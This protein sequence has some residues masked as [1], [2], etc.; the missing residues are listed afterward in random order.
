MKIESHKLPLALIAALLIISASVAGIFG[1]GEF[2]KSV[3][4]NRLEKK[5][6]DQTRLTGKFVDFLTEGIETGSFFNLY[7]EEKEYVKA[8][9]N[10]I[11]LLVY[12]DNGLEY[13]SD[14]TFEV[15]PFYNQELFGEAVI[16]LQN[17]WFVPVISDLPDYK[18]VGLLRV[19][20]H[21]GIENDIISS[22][23]TEKLKPSGEIAFSQQRTEGGMAIFNG[24]GDYLF[25]VSFPDN[26]SSNILVTVSLVLWTLSLIT[27]LFIVASIASFFNK[28]GKG[29]LGILLASAVLIS[30]YF[31]FLFT[32]KPSV[33]NGTELFSPLIFSLNGLIPSLGH[34]LVV[35]AIIFTTTMLMN[36]HLPVKDAESDTTLPQEISVVL[37]FLAG[38]LVVCFAHWIFS[39]ILSE[40]NI[41]LEFYKIL[42]LNYLSIVA[43]ISVMITFFASFPLFLRAIRLIK[44]PTLKMSIFPFAASLAVVALLFHNNPLTIFAVTTLLLFQI[45]FAV[46]TSRKKLGIFNL[47]VLYSLLI[48][49]YTLTVIA[50]YSENKRDEK[51]K[52]QALDFSIEND[53]D[54]EMLLMDLWP[55]MNADNTLQDMMSV[56]RFGN[57]DYIMINDY[58]NEN[59]F[60]DYWDNYIVSIYL[61]EE[62]Q[63]IQ[64]DDGESTDCF[65]FFE[66]RINEH[67]HVIS[68]TDFY[69]TDDQ[70]GRTCYL[71][72]LYFDVGMRGRN[73]LFIELFSDVNIFQPGY[74]ELLLDKKYRTNS[75]LSDY[76][77]IKYISGSTVISYGEYDYNSE[78]H[79]YTAGMQ[80]DYKIFKED[81]FKHILFKNGETTVVISRPSLTGPNLLISFAYLFAF[82]LILVNISINLTKVHRFNPVRSPNLRQKFQI[83]IIAILLISSMFVGFLVANLTI[84]RY[85]SNHYEN[86]K[87]KIVS[88]SLALYNEFAGENIIG[89]PGSGDINMNLND[90][91]IY[92]SNIFNTD[93]NLYDTGGGLVATS[94]PELF[95]K[96][97]S[98]TR[99]DNTA[100][101]N[102]SEYGKTGF[103][104][105]EKVGNLK[106]I[107]S[108][109]PFTNGTGKVIG[110]LN[111][112]YFRMQS[113]FAKE[114]SDMIVAVVNFTL[115]LII[116]TMGIAVFIVGKIT[117]PLSMLSRGLAS[118]ELG[119]KAEHIDYNDQDEIGD[120]IKQYNLMVDELDESATKLANSER[121]YA[122]REMAK[123]IAHEIKNPLTPMKL[124]VQ[125]LHKS[126]KDKVGDFDSRMDN[127]AKNQIE[128][129]DNLSSIASAFSS[130]A[131][132]PGNKPSKIDL[133]DQIKTTL[134]LFR[135]SQNIAFQESWPKEKKVFVYAD[136]E[137]LNGV[138][139]NLIKNGIQSIPQGK[140]GVIV[141]S[142]KVLRDKCL[143]SIADNGIGIPE[144]VREKMFT[145]YFTTKS[146]G[147]GLGLSIV[148]K[149]V[150]SCGGKIWFESDFQKGTTFFVEL[151]LMFTVEKPGND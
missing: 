5:V 57:D 54:A 84:S 48:S 127:F 107:S 147:T 29:L 21:Y 141:V 25:T 144:D 35:S 108:Y 140:E 2:G 39:R 72:K 71:G 3:V 78:D 126:F 40:S 76:S 37:L 11:T 128:Y 95:N 1:K 137:Q 102:L 45:V 33:V 73:G 69:F 114:I 142:L 112:P 19:S 14:N 13:W 151:P 150:E 22:G 65:T 53:P 134:D 46:L 113:S 74:S 20:T 55:E 109:A 23:L 44:G 56:A 43:Y 120:L 110:F 68:G 30:T 90:V 36:I 138:F 77:F 124:N 86:I 66:E 88:V 135:S 16:F 8:T 117:A 143:V 106:Y 9:K 100:L 59:Y 50:I 148:K 96:D 103:S 101:I 82:A 49:I 87:E 133:V 18:I 60:R 105:T 62:R 26:A 99:M 24:M 129:I 38:S 118:V 123:Q 31:L 89:E 75:G 42:D 47:T 85:E 28:I 41:N 10:D 94:R 98:S 7:F 34:L 139:S 136:R 92:L 67:G 104:H 63:T 115:L 15:P 121:E 52:I 32:G 12:S 51:I 61:C 64:I 116:I 81:G 149:H 111:L 80:S 146:S 58:L 97:L 145:P 79:E 27:I 4:V 130:F 125:Q 131:R 93:I 122:W 6:V 17:G 132:M 91:L 70:A 83:A 119:K